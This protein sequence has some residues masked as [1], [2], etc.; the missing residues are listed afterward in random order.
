[1]GCGSFEGMLA[2]IVQQYSLLR[3]RGYYKLDGVVA[4]VCVRNIA[5]CN[6]VGIIE[7]TTANY[8]RCGGVSERFAVFGHFTAIDDI[9]A[10][11]S[12]RV[13]LRIQQDS[14]RRSILHILLSLSEFGDPAGGGNRG[15]H[16]HV[17]HNGPVHP[18]MLESIASRHC[19]NQRHD[20]S[21][22]GDH[23]W[24]HSRCGGVPDSDVLRVAYPSEFANRAN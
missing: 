22:R 11:D 15:H 9:H 14:S 17:D 3:D 4:V 2:T 21:S 20:S 10:T 1:M 13:R 18:S 6:R 24:D 12:P 5:E 16:A 8:F 19:A 7:S 23:G